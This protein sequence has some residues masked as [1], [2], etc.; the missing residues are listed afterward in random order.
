[1]R[2]A[3]IARVNPDSTVNLRNAHGDEIDNAATAHGYVPIQFEQ[4]VVADV[5]GEPV[6]IA[7]VY[8]R[9]SDL[10]DPE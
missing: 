3:T 1:M 2:F 5:D 4:V 10:G 8:N 7:A 6:V 9:A